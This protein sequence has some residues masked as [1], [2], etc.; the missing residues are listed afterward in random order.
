VGPL[1]SGGCRVLLNRRAPAAR[2]DTRHP[3]GSV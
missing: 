1:R 3:A 2:G